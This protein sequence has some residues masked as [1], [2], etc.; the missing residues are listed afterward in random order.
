MRLMPLA[1]LVNTS[2]GEQTQ[3][4]I[5]IAV[6]EAKSL[7]QIKPGFNVNIKVMLAEKDQALLIPYEALVRENNREVV[8]VVGQDAVV[9]KKEIE[10]DLSNELYF[11]VLSGLKA[12][13]KVVLSPDEQIQDGVKVM[14]NAAGQ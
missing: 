7:G 1:E 6:E 2:Q 11:E 12:G 5:R 10:I 3:V 9:S 14:V 4:K 13:D 8:Y